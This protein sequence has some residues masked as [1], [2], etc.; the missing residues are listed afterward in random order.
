MKFGKLILIMAAILTLLTTAVAI[1]SVE[2]E[3]SEDQYVER[4]EYQEIN[5]TAEGDDLEK[6]KIRRNIDEEGWET[7]K[8]EDCNSEECEINKSYRR[9]AAGSIEFKILAESGEDEQE[10]ETVNITWRDQPPEHE[11]DD[12]S[13]NPSEDR[14]LS[15]DE[16]QDIE[17]IAEG[18]N[19][20]QLEIQMSEEKDDWENI[21]TEDCSGGTECEV[22]TEKTFDEETEKY[23]RI[24]ATAGPEQEL[25]D[26]VKIEWRDAEVCD[27]EVSE[28]D[29][30]PRM[31]YQGEDSTASIDVENDGDTQ[32]VNVEFR[33]R[34][35]TVHRDSNTVD[36]GETK[37]FS[38]E[39]TTDRDYST[40]R[41]IV[42]TEGEPCG[43]KEFQRTNTL[44]LLDGERE[45]E[46]TVYV[47]D[48]DDNPLESANIEINDRNKRTNADG[49]TIFKLP[50][51]SHT[52][53]VSKDGYYSE[54]RTV[55]LGAGENKEKTINLETKDEDYDEKGN[56]K[57]IVEDKDGDKI[58]DARVRAENTDRIIKRTDSNGEAQFSLRPDNY[59]IRAYKPG[60]STE[61][62][63]VSIEKSDDITRRFKLEEIEDSKL[64]IDNISHEST[65]CKDRSLKTEI[66]V[67]NDGDKSKATDLIAK[68]FDEEIAKTFEIDAGETRE[69]EITFTRA[70]PLGEQELEFELRND[71]TDIDTSTVEVEDCTEQRETT[72]RTPTGLTAEVS[73]REVLTGETVT[74]RGY[75]DGV[76]GSTEVEV[77]VDGRTV[78]KTDSRRDG[79]YTAYIRPRSIGTANID[80]KAGDITRSRSV[81]VLP[82]AHIDHLDA[83]DRVFQG[84]EFEICADVQTQ[85]TSR[86]L[87]TRDGETIQSK[88]GRGEVCFDVE[89]NYV[90]EQE[91]EIKALTSGTDGSA[92][93]RIEVLEQGNQVD[94]FPDQVASVRSGDSIVKVDLYNTED[95]LQTYDLSLEGLPSTWLSQTD[96]TVNLPKG[97]KKTAYFY[98]TPREE[99]EFNP[100]LSVEAD[101]ET[102]YSEEIVM[103]IGGSD[104]REKRSIWQRMRDRFSNW[105]WA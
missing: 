58:E 62:R 20:T 53:D 79:Y 41:A 63:S 88:D 98:L 32:D 93:K 48:K 82:T 94:S 55:D 56:L 30:D 47:K 103:E 50:S 80:V 38:T 70:Q 13:I 43:T 40:I 12:V 24:N 39:L 28:L 4:G 95:S 69:K 9:E 42:E 10:S 36:A 83:P 6:I 5:G 31:I 96:K 17:G 89:P 51:G 25:S 65:V 78:T 76:R 57:T 33:V 26:E 99:G 15:L 46:L 23:F 52:M 19:L 91:Y 75:V 66:T 81:E 73:P 84:E 54:T 72:T 18:I 71:Y 87:L 8:E 16:S 45:A 29:L 37:Q 35:D 74:V 21:E 64:T 68:G 85:S 7:D 97:E 2:I 27:I 90:G 59:D 86:I 22:D 44:F 105:Y 3:P 60:Y 67:S 61:T 92:S 101:G 1:D 14:V 102:I 100:T 49:R 34:G 104:V 11:I 77:Q